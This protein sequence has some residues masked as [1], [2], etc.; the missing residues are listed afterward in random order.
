MS[1]NLQLIKS[2]TGSGVSTVSVTNCFTDKYDVYKIVIKDAD[3]TGAAS[4][5]IRM[6]DSSGSEV[7]AADY[8][9]AYLGI[10]SAHG[11]SQGRNTGQ[12]S[13]SSLGFYDGST[14]G[15]GVFYLY[16]PFE[17]VY[18]FIQGQVSYFETSYS[19]ANKYIGA[20]KQ[21]ASMTGFNINLTGQTFD[22]ISISV[23]G[24]N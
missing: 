1:D 23:Y 12:T 11:F 21:A 22:S 20:L 17:A 19:S 5:F 24:V 15:G 3:V 14:G 2:V 8:D 16:N 6:L 9:R 7:S 4:A 13:F 10:Y 18:T